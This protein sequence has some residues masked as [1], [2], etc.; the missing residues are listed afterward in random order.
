MAIDLSAKQGQQLRVCGRTAP[1]AKLA[2]AAGNL[3]SKAPKLFAN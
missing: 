3:V 1:D 2:L